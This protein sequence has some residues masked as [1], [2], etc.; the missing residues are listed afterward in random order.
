M[1]ET[2]LHFLP[3]VASLLTLGALAGLLAGMLGIGGGIVLVPGIYYTMHALGYG[4]EAIMHV[5]VGTSLAIV[6]PTGYVSMR[7]HLKREAVRFDIVK[8]LGLAILAGS[9]AGT[10]VARLLTGDGLQLL[11]GIVVF[12]L[13]IFMVMQPD[14]PKS[15]REMPRRLWQSVAGLIFGTLSTL[16]GIGGATMTVPYMTFHHVPIHKA[17]GT[18]A[19]LGLFIA[20]PG[21][22][23]FVAA[24]LGAEG[25]P[26]FSV[27]YVNVLTWLSI[28]PASV[29][30][31]P[32][33]A[34]LAHQMP[35]KRLKRFFSFFIM[36]VSV[37]M[38]WDALNGG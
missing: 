22:L 18:A 38:L 2:I 19:F 33:G 12:A 29:L 23:G 13:S 8:T 34:H 31:A 7:S 14:A 37:K 30:M 9:I 24:G 21:M 35:V 25:R 17:V 3:V 20:L 28:V 16:L 27:G 26:P 6:V 1:I 15:M 32:V 11:F 36:I 10:L 5:A 4:G